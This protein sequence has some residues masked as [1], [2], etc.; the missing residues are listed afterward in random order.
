MPQILKFALRRFHTRKH[1]HFNVLKENLSEQKETTK[2]DQHI[3]KDK[4]HACK[5]EDS[6]AI[7]CL[8][9]DRRTRLDK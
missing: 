2:L 7:F 4:K 8:S 9:L 1:P 6:I 5:S 3:P